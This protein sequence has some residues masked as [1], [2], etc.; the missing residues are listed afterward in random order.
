MLSRYRILD[1][2]GGHEAIGGQILADLGADVVLVEPHSAGLE[3]ELR[4]EL[5]PGPRS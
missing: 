1:F 5:T 2:T 4:C 3:F